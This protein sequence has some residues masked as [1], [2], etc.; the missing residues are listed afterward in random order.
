M[1]GSEPLK[2]QDVGSTPTLASILTNNYSFKTDRR[3][4]AL[5]H[6]VFGKS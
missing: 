4:N 5:N 6:P 3:V 1:V 2:L